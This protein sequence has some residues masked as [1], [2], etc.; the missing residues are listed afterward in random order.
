[1]L[2]WH[3]RIC[4]EMLDEV[5][6]LHV[7]RNI[8]SGNELLSYIGSYKRTRN[9]LDKWKMKN[10]GP[11]GRTYLR[12]EASVAIVGGGRL[13][14]QPAAIVGRYQIRWEPFRRCS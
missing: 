3:S 4:L 11:R 14:I 12:K 1:L 9:E 10:R 13:Q 5:D 2:R 8:F 7:E 6:T